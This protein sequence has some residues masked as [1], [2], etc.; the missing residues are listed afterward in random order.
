[1]ILNNNADRVQAAASFKFK[2]WDVSM[3]TIF[4]KDRIEVMAWNANTDKVFNTVE[5][6][7]EFINDLD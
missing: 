4:N 1:M 6:A 3:S 7:I 2:G 5:D